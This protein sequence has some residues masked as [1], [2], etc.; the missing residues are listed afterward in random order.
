[1]YKTTGILL[2]SLMMGTVALAGPWHHAHTSI[3]IDNHFDGRASVFI[4]GHFSGEIR[5]DTQASFD[6]WPGDNEV[7]VMR[8][9]IML[10]DREVHT[11]PGESV[12]VSVH[13]PIGSLFVR[14]TGR[15]PLLVGADQRSVWIRPGTGANLVVT[16]GNVALASQVKDHHGVLRVISRQTVW[17]EPGKK[18]SAAVAYNP[19]HRTGILIKNRDHHEVGVRVGNRDYGLLRSGGE[20]FVAVGPGTARVKVTRRGCTA[21]S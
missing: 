5:G 8:N 21:E 15:A 1:M 12:K 11:H 18:G 7:H 13:A 4:D 16:T 3:L 19:P 14:N 17:V 2:A 6:V 9:G 10:L 20:M